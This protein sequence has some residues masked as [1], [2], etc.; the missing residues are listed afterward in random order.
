MGCA[1]ERRGNHASG[2]AWAKD[3]KVEVCKAPLPAWK[4]FASDEYEEFE[5]AM[6]EDVDI[7]LIHTRLATQGSPHKNVNNHPVFAGKCAVVHNGMISNDDHLFRNTEYPRLAE[8]DT[9][10]IRAFVDEHGLT[11]KAVTELNRMS[12]SAACA[13]VH[14]EFPRKL[15]LIRSGSPMVLAWNPD[16]KQLSWASEKDV[17][18][19][20]A[21]TPIPILNT[22]MQ[23]TKANLYFQTVM[24]DTAYIF[25]REANGMEWHG[26]F[27][28]SHYYTPPNYRVWENF[29]D[30]MTKK[31]GT[32]MLKEPR[33]FTKTDGTKWAVCR[34]PRCAKVLH[35]EEKLQ[36]LP[37][38]KV[39]CSFCKTDLAEQPVVM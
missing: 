19:K 31:W 29:E 3:D 36:K 18:H 2:I 8:V 24:R 39:Y 11:P 16:V 10:I 27:K 23:P 20:V 13:I 35:M 4:F 9:D 22:Y 6:P 28:T 38:W 12:G 17:L 21:T 15:M 26:E 34:N 1:L 7:V 32:A 25:S 33:L 14:P 37:L 30:S 5:K